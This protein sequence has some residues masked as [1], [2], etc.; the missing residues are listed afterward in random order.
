MISPAELSEIPNGTAFEAVRRLRPRWLQTRGVSSPRSGAGDF[1]RVF[2]D[3]APVGGIQAL[4]RLAVQDVDSLV[5]MNAS[6][7]TTRYGTGFTGGLI[8]VFTKGGG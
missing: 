2:I 8:K 7:A 4:S 1:A 3:N 5:F 6:D